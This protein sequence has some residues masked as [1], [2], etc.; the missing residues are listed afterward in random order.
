MRALA[1]TEHAMIVSIWHMLTTDEAYNELGYN[2]NL[3]DAN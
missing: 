2:V 1:A 3:S